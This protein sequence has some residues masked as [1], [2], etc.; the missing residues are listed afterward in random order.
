VETAQGRYLKTDGANSLRRAP[1]Y[2]LLALKNR[3]RPDPSLK[4]RQ[5]KS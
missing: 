2:F 3:L 4:L 1:V 5:A